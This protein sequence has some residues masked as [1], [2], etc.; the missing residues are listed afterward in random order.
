MSA[1]ATNGRVTFLD[2]YGDRWLVVC[3]VCNQRARVDLHGARL[4]AYC[5]GGCPP[6][7][8][9]TAIDVEQVAAELREDAAQRN[10][11]DGPGGVFSEPDLAACVTLGAF[12]AAPRPPLD[13]YVTTSDGRTVLLARETALLFAGP[14]GLGKSLAA[15]FDLAGRLAAEDPSDW[16]GFRVRAGLQVLLLSF[17][18]S[19]EDTAERSASIVPVDARDRFLL[20]DRWRA[21]PPPRAD[22]AGLERL[23]DEIRRHEIDV[24]VID[25]GSAF[26]SAA[27]DCSKGLP[28][29][30]F[31]AIERVRELSG[32]PVAVIV[33]AHT[34]KA[35]RTGAKVDEL[36]EIA[37]T[38]QRKVDAAIVMRRD[39]E[40]RGPRRRLVFPKT[41][42]GPEPADKIATLPAE[43]AEEPPC[44]ELLQ[45]LDATAVKAGTTAEE[46]AAWVRE[47][48]AVVSPGAIRERFSI[49]DSTL[50]TRRARLAE[51]GIIWRDHEGYGTAEQWEARQARLGDV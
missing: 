19:D 4:S 30:A 20:W 23:A 39:G 33:V 40:Q 49:A 13:P 31:R 9:L 35:D 47:Q 29:E 22:G 26:F 34:K 50:R 28:E 27:H 12:L 5:F 11:H 24:L 46:I 14:S 17:E 42:R 44:L 15:A 16:L 48:P 25:T 6:E 51:L 41:R 3:P 2:D 43:G 8:T 36:E 1:A 21:G 38:F 37:G 18:G 45:D 10:G 7:A 32:R